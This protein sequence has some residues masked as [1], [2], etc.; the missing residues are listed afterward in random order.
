MFKQGDVILIGEDAPTRAYVGTIFRMLEDS[1]EEGFYGG[2]PILKCQAE[3]LKTGVEAL[4]VRGAEEAALGQ[5]VDFQFTQSWLGSL[6]KIGEGDIYVGQ[7]V[8]IREDSR[9]YGE[10]RANPLDVAGEVIRF[11]PGDWLPLVVRWEN[12]LLTLILLRVWKLWQR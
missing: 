4:Q 10:G 12:G 8:K 7:R 6:R 3:V 11:I 1:Q 5:G 9:F 2:V